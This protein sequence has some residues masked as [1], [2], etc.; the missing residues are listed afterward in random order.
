[1]AVGKRS[2][3]D[4]RITVVRRRLAPGTIL[5]GSL[6]GRAVVHSA[7]F[8]ARSL[9]SINL[10]GLSWSNSVWSL[11]RARHAKISRAPVGVYKSLQLKPLLLFLRE[12]VPG[13][14]PGHSA[15]AG[16]DPLPDAC[17]A[18]GPPVSCRL[19]VRRG[20]KTAMTGANFPVTVSRHPYKPIH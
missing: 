8:A 19:F 6:A 20:D 3:L 17:N 13:D 14:F 9:M 15:P 16:A 5:D 2:F 11:C 10:V 1:V 4:Y 12:T 7:S 18:S